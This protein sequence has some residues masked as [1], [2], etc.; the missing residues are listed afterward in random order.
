MTK[1]KVNN[2]TPVSHLISQGQKEGI[3]GYKGGVFWLTGLSGAGKS[4]LAMA[5]EAALVRK[6][7]NCLVLDGDNVRHGLNKDLGFSPAD[8]SENIR[9]V[10]EVAS[11]V[12]KAGFICIASFI[13]PLSKDRTL[14]R[15]I[16]GNN[17]H[18]IYIQASV[19]LCT[20]RDPKGLY[21][22]AK[23]G[24][25]KEF[26]GVSAPYEEPQDPDVI[27]NTDVPNVEACIFKLLSYIEEQINLNPSIAGFRKNVPNEP[28]EP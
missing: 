7:I 8:R 26:T 16:I 13:S 3:F 11:L 17:F 25:L 4:T 28:N 5:A 22:L 15:Q 23:T 1:K 19:E 27:I 24:I 12:S 21:K 14:A 6:G 2:I 20:T 18:E 10:S 9:R